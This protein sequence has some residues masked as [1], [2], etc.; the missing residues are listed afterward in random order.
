M[1]RITDLRI[2]RHHELSFDRG[3]PVTIL[4][5]GKRL[6]GFT[7]EPVAVAL[8]ASGI[9][10]TMRSFK[11]HRPRGM[12]CV[13]GKC[14]S[15]LMR[16]DGIPNQRAC[17]VRCRD[18]MIIQRQGAIPNATD[19][20]LFTADFL[21]PKRLDYHHMLT[22]SG[23]LNRL[24]A[25]GVR[26][27]SGLGALPDRSPTETTV[28]R[29]IECDVAVFGAGPA[30]IAASLGAAS[31][32]VS[33]ILVDDHTRPGGHLLGF[34]EKIDDQMTGLTYCSERA[35]LLIEKGVRFFSNNECIGYANEGFFACVKE[36]GLIRLRP[37][38]AIIATGAYDQNFSFPQND[39]PNIFSARGLLKLVNQYGICPGVQ[40]L[41]IGSNDD[42]L[43]LAMRLPE[44]GVRVV[45][46][47][48]TS[49]K[50]QGNPE[51]ADKIQSQSIPV[52][53]RYKI[54]RAL[55]RFVLKGAELTPNGGGDSVKTRCDII[56]VGAPS[57]PAYELA[58][59]AG[60]QV[61]FDPSV[62][63]FVPEHDSLGRTNVETVFVAGEITGPNSVAQLR[64]SGRIAG[65]AAANDVRPSQKIS[66][67]LDQLLKEM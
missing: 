4:F 27:A 44:I 6:R 48:E 13:N 45:G 64:L 40:V 2:D 36:G 29:D 34:P 26:A 21:F 38:R 25:T 35:S 54:S 61:A 57:A 51:W 59:Q 17:K 1:D 33:V 18:G 14:A 10:V 52:F 28:I 60:V 19:D 7:N 32:K 49:G 66:A 3:E 41:L 37:K 16:I 56:A 55:G 11:Y 67:K 50:I 22:K 12:F 23:R 42:I 5:E 30:G 46:V 15:C 47:A 9:R 20:L 58:S 31:G 43:S 53:L 39:L 8:F 65:L 62:P 63:G 24:F